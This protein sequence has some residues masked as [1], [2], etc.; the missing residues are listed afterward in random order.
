MS[1][2]GRKVTGMRVGEAW[3]VLRHVASVDSEV[4]V[5]IGLK[6][7]QIIT[8]FG[9]LKGAATTSSHQSLRGAMDGSEKVKMPSVLGGWRR[10]LAC[11]RRPLAHRAAEHGVG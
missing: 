9:D 5:V 6:M 8:G 4:T 7:E 10:R 1:R 3:V 11:L 2:T